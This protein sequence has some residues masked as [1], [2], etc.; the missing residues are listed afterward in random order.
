MSEASLERI[1][2]TRA[3]FVVEIAQ[4]SVLQQCR[5][6]PFKGNRRRLK[7]SSMMNDA[8]FAL[9][10]NLYSYAFSSALTAILR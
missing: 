4:V 5:N 1:G 8:F 10:L 6:E 7:T 3:V 2:V 9:K